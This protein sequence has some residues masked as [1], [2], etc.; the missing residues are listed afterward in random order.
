M[1]RPLRATLTLLA[2]ATACGTVK[3]AAAPTPPPNPA[4]IPPV[5]GPGNAPL[6]STVWRVQSAEQVDLWLHSFALLAPDSALVPYFKRGYRD[7][8]LALRRERGVSTML[9]SSRARLV[10]RIAANP[11]LGTMPQFIPMY[12]DSYEQLRL[13]IDLFLRANGNPAAATDAA[14]RNTLAMFAS[15]F[16]TGA[17]RE[18]LRLFASAVDDEQRRFYHDYWASE[19]RSHSGAMAHADTLWQRQWRPALQR[20]L[21]NTQQRNG[22]L[23]LSFPIGGEGRTIQRGSEQN[24]IA[25]PMPDGRDDAETVLYVMAHEVTGALA[26]AALADTTTPADRR[27]GASVKFEQSAAVRAGALLLERTVPSAVPGYMR[28]YLRQAGRESPNDPRAAFAAAFT[29]PAAALT[30]MGQQIDV[31]LGGI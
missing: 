16:P 2:V 31:T 13:A 5:S 9:D 28:Y 25:A 22:A 4:S 26:S 11:S 29:V 20:F 1:I 7:R 23:L 27:A 30:A 6:L 3:P 17:D 19:M 12:F 15:V 18:W 21:T 8:M 10:Q 14:T 24:L